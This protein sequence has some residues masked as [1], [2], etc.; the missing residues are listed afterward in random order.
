MRIYLVESSAGPRL[1]RAATRH[2]AIVHVAKTDF[3]ARVATQDDLVTH[4]TTVEIEQAGELE[5]E[6]A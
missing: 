5:Q 6:A 2:Q 3:Q 4:L 1:V